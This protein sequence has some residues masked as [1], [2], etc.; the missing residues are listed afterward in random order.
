MHKF[1]STSFWLQMFIN[2]FFT[3]ICIY[4]IKKVATQFNV[5]VVSTIAQEV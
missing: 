4:C 1:F 2:T 3:M 5:P